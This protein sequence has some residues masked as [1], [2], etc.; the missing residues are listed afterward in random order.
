MKILLTERF[1]KRVSKLSLDE[2]A[3]VFE[4]LLGIPLAL[5]NPHRHS[6]IGMRKLHKSGI[7]EV[8]IGLGLRLVFAFRNRELMLAMV[9]SH[10]D[11]RK[12]LAGL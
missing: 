4:A 5:K 8:R 3:K 11:V 12:Y 2:R 9:G 10:D 1:Q 6:G 7:Y